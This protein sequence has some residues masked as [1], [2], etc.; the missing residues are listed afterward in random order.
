MRKILYVIL[1]Y[2]SMTP[3]FATGDSLYY[4]TA[5]D[6]IFLAVDESNEKIF[7]HQI[8]KKQTL[9]S[10]AK[11]YGMTIEELT[12]Y[13]E[14]LKNPV[15][16]IGQKIKIPIP[17]R[18]IIRYKKKDFIERIHV[19]VFYMVQKGDNLFHISKRHFKMPMDSVMIRNQLTS[20]SIKEGQKLFMGW[21]SI[22][23][24]PSNYRSI[25]IL[26]PIE[27]KNEAFKEIYA[28]RRYRKREYKE[29]GVAYWQKN[30]RHSGELFAMHRK[31]PINSIITVTNPMTKRSA[32]VRVIGKLPKTAYGKD[33]VVILSPKAAR[34]LGAKDPRFFVK[35]KYVK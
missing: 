28:K 4:L 35:V 11:F 17:N 15:I 27:Q 6:T 12:L 14:T 13:N 33:V 29:S 2:I 22:Y 3:L 32:Y 9:F 18:A 10:L 8:E 5:K 31:A 1:C 7:E 30:S 20:H 23:G 25:K 16:S 19:P 26:S 21:M 24:V 34:L